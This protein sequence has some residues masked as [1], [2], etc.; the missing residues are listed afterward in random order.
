MI[1]KS[2]MWNGKGLKQLYCCPSLLKSLTSIRMGSL[3][4]LDTRKN[5]GNNI[6]WKS[7]NELKHA[8]TIQTRLQYF[9]RLLSRVQG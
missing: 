3:K 9:E 2:T 6:R 8:K 1:K 5:V 4:L 7:C